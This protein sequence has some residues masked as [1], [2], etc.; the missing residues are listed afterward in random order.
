MSDTIIRVENLSKKYQLSHKQP[1]R[2]V[3][4]RDVLADRTKQLKGRLLGSKKEVHQ[5]QEDFWALK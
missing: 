1:E 5:A 2:Y 3:A 4:L